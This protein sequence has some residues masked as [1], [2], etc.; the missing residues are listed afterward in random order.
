VSGARVV[1]QPCSGAA[2]QRFTWYS[3]GQLR[4]FG[5]L[6]LDAYGG[7]GR[8]GDPIVVFTCHGA[9]NQQWAASTAGEIKGINAKCLDIWGGKGNAGNQVNL[10]ACHGGLN[11]QWDNSV[12]VP[13]PSPP[14]VPSGTA[15]FGVHNDVVMLGWSWQRDPALQRARALNAKI[16]RGSLHWQNV[17]P[18][19]GVRNWQVPDAGVNDLIAAGI[20]PL[21]TIWGSPSWANGVPTT[22][23][24]YWTYVPTDAAR[25]RTWLDNY[26][27]FVRDAVTRYKGKVRK[28]ELWNEANEHWCWK[29]A[30]NV[31]LYVTWYNEV[32]QTIKSVDPSAQVALGGLTGLT[33]SGSQDISGKRF[34]EMVYDR[35][36]RPDVVSIHPYA[37]KNQ[38]P[39]VTLA[40]E[41][42]FTDIAKIRDVMVARGQGDAKIWITEWGWPVTAVSE[43]TQAEYVDKAHRMLVS[44]YPYVTVSTYF[45]DIDT[46]T[47]RYGLFAMDGRMRPA[48][49]RFR[50]FAATH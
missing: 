10:Y 40:W 32:R 1:V 28:W 3:G 42:N 4:V 44:L 41:N 26:K 43:Q 20:E 49:A 37:M 48:G 17:E 22:T 31:D 29:P 15:L 8:D 50:D 5:S 14:S 18:Q 13:E 25:F 46:Q 35:G 6:C 33:V 9:R 7:Q 47:Y 2:S 45:L 12:K 38:A 39:D 36:V 21:V 24:Q 34:L 19:K 23:S 11:Q 27:L 30:P 16:A